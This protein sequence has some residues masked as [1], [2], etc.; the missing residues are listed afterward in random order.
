[1]SGK[2]K[3]KLAFKVEIP[4]QFLK[5]K[6]FSEEDMSVNLDNIQITA[7]DLRTGSRIGKYK[8]LEYRLK[9]L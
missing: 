1:M 3:N 4:K 7:F 9:F 6:L 2:N 8:A 5:N